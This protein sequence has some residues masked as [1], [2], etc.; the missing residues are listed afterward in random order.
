[1]ELDYIHIFICIYEGC[2][3]S[4]YFSRIMYPMDVYGYTN[5]GRLKSV[6]YL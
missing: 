4:I 5:M 1:V 6:I 3:G 2:D